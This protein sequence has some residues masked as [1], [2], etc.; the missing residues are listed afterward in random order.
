MVTALWHGEALIL[1]GAGSDVFALAGRLTFSLRAQRESKQRESAPR[2]TVVGCRRRSPARDASCAGAA[3]LASLKQ[4][5]RNS[6]TPPAVL[7]SDEGKDGSRQVRTSGVRLESM[8]LT[9]MI[10]NR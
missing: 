10:C 4:S 9:C 1:A 6:R 8:A 5:S 3:E 7:G 2:I